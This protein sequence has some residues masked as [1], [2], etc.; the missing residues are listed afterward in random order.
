MRTN[1]VSKLVTS[2]GVAAV[3]L[4]SNAALAAEGDDAGRFFTPE[5][6]EATVAAQ[7]M[8][9][10]EDY[11]SAIVQF[12]AIEAQFEPSPYELGVILYLK[13]GAKYQTDDI[14]GAIADWTRALEEGEL[15]EQER[16]NLEHNIAQLQSQ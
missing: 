8:L 14:D 12:D 6:G 5:V 2:I 4:A 10:N 15:R 16:A 1:F 3:L 11:A 9:T 7:Q 13:G